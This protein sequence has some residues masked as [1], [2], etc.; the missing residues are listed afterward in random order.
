MQLMYIT[1]RVTLTTE[2][3]A[4]QTRTLNATGVATSSVTGLTRYHDVIGRTNIETKKVLHITGQ[5]QT[6]EK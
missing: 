2:D 3:R 6:T 1:F 4:R 5:Q